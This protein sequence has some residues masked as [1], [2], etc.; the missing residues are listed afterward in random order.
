MA[1]EA[2]QGRNRAKQASTAA[3]AGRAPGHMFCR[4]GDGV[5][6]DDSLPRR[7]MG[8]DE[9]GVAHFEMVDSLLLERV[10]LEGVLSR[11]M[12]LRLTLDFPVWAH[13]VCH[14][15]DKL[16]EVRHRFVHVDYMGPVA[17][18]HLGAP[19]GFTCRRHGVEVAS[20]SDTGMR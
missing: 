5:L 17:L 12:R 14:I 8:G 20:L 18:L 10:Q 1:L 11:N 6:S 15:R 9:D 16:G 4:Q 3:A 2:C 13:L 19:Q 7:C